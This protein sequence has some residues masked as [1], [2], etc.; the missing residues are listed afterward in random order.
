MT[1]LC[2]N[3]RKQHVFEYFVDFLVGNIAFNVG[4][5]HNDVFGYIFE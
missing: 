1:S 5:T 2:A 4:M 3:E